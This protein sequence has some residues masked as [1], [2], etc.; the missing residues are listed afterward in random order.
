MT[1]LRIDTPETD[2]TIKAQ[3]ECNGHFAS[4]TM[5]DILEREM[6]AVIND[7]LA[8]LPEQMQI[9]LRLRF[10]WKMTLQEIGDRIKISREMVRQ[11]EAT[12]LRKLRHPNR[13]KKLTEWIEYCNERKLFYQ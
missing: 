12:G 10:F 5:N 9:I 7:S 4:V 8:E 3:A 1:T 11:K 6:E 13:I 2:D